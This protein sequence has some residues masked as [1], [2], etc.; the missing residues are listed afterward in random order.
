MRFADKNSVQKGRWLKNS[1]VL[2]LSIFFPL[3]KNITEQQPFYYLCFVDDWF[4]NDIKRAPSMPSKKTSK[5]CQS[6]NKSSSSLLTE[7]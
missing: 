5:N 3:E 1:N 4:K 7:D 6:F 2:N